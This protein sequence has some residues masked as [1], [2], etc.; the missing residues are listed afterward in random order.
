MCC[1]RSCREIQ[2]LHGAFQF[3]PDDEITRDVVVA[4]D[5]E[6][7]HPMMREKL[8]LPELAPAATEAEAA[9]AEA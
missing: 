5:G 9:T 8:G 4:R 7:Q 6:I 1:L 3:D 2:S